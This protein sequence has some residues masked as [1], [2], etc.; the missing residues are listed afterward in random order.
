VQKAGREPAAFIMFN[1]LRTFLLARSALLGLIV[2]PVALLVALYVRKPDF[3]PGVGAENL[4]ASYHVLLTVEA[5]RRG[6]LSTHYLLPTVS[7]AQPND[8][9]IPWGATLRARSGDQIYTS[10]SPLGFLVPQ[11]AMSSLGAPST[12]AALGLF[13][14]F[15][16][17]ITALIIYLLLRRMLLFG[18]QGVGT[19]T[20]GALVGASVAVFS[21]EVLQ[22]HGVV[23]WS[24]SLYQLVMAATLWFLFQHLASP[25][26]HPRRRHVR[27]LA[28]LAFAGAMTEWSA[29]LFN[30]GLIVLFWRG[31]RGELVSRLMAG[32]IAGGTVLAAVVTFAHFSLA[33]GVQA[34]AQAFAL[35][36]LTRS[37]YNGSFSELVQGYGHS[38]G[39]F[40]VLLFA[41]LAIEYFD[42][43]D[44]SRTA[45]RSRK[46]TFLLWAATIPL[47]E[48]LLLLG[49]ATYFSFDRLKFVFP[50]ALVLA[51][52]FARRRIVGRLV[53]LLAVGMA[54]AQ[55]VQ[56]RHA[57][58]FAFRSWAQAD[59]AN[60]QF[61]ERVR[62]AVDLKCATLS[63]AFNVRGYASLLFLR[64]IYEYQPP[65]RAV[66][67]MQERGGCAAVYLEG[68]GL[69][70]D[71]PVF[72]RATIIRPDGSRSE[73]LSD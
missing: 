31:V 49:H 36:F 55:N 59:A 51:I 39:L 54:C 5:L 4:E 27:I 70:P 47:I 15:V 44:P 58:R 65:D 29:Y 37:A 33:L 12:L 41:L 63:S 9:S 69:F 11:L 43:S 24:H 17:A 26:D 21:R 52:G 22:S 61:V 14:A 73:V 35:R 30:L 19:S 16:G 6:S 45:G 1:S 48:N 20:V 64:G 68:N 38:Y 66:P 46:L 13:N 67:L 25:P 72:K 23:Y 32:A 34:T 60:R 53:L 28:V 57:D 50:A 18:G 40:L 62:Q 7:L 2:L 10:F 71:M 3:E 42:V 56:T 8:K